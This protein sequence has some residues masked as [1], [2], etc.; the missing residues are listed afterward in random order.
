M[1]TSRRQGSTVLAIMAAMW[2]AVAALLPG[3]ASASINVSWTP[4][5]K[6]ARLHG[7]LE[8]ISCPSDQLCLGLT[9]NG[10]LALS[11]NPSVGTS[12]HLTSSRHVNSLSCTAHLCLATIVRLKSLNVDL[13]ASTHPAGGLASF[14]RVTTSGNFDY[15]D[16]FSCPTSSFCAGLDSGESPWSTSDQS[17]WFSRNPGQSGSWHHLPEPRNRF[18]TEYSNLV[19]TSSLIC[20]AYAT[21]AFTEWVAAITEPTSPGSRW[22]FANADPKTGVPN[23]YCGPI[24]CAGEQFTGGACVAPAECL[25]TTGYGAVVNS[26]NIQAAPSSWTRTVIYGNGIHRRGYY[27]LSDPVC[28][29]G[30]LCYVLGARGDLLVSTDPFG[31]DS[32]AW[33]DFH[34]GQ[35]PWPTVRQT[36]SC[37]SAQVCFVLV[38]YSSGRQS[39]FRG[40]VD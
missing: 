4:S 14:V 1:A 10:Q 12:W 29:S 16:T 21:N 13:Y 27:G 33:Q 17:A 2:L 15:A 7:E 39:V 40:H 6:L 28:F 19:C 32:S 30:S 9:V 20:L 24:A 3:V 22:A 35:Q 38:R 5:G 23:E 37:P 36:L 31:A 18:G 26:P 34:I 8:S 11:R 25:L